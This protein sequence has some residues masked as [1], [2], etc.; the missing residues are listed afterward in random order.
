MQEKTGDI[1]E[2]TRNCDWLCITT[3][4]IVKKNGRAVMGRGIALQAKRRFPYI[5]LVLA[6]RIRSRGNVV[7]PLVKAENYWILSF[8][9]KHHWRTPSDIDLI[10]RSAEQL[11]QHF[12]EQE[13]KPLVVMPRPGC[14][15]GQLEWSDVKRV[16]E[17]ILDDP[18][19]LIIC[20]QEF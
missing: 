3:N 10:R 18:G 20:H 5:D 8:P 17:P 15:N 7:S 14:G 2:Y 4:G 1:W 12:D 11:K 9:T 6:E 16:I 13:K 19:F